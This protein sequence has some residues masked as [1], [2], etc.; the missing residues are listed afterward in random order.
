LVF[1][2]WDSRDTQVKLPRLVASTIRAYDV[3]KL[4]RSAQFNPPLDYAKEA[5]FDEEFLDTG[6]KGTTV[7]SFFGLKAAPAVNQH[8]GIIARGDI[9][10]EAILSLVALRAIGPRGSAGDSVRRYILGISLV[11]LTHDR[12]HDL[13]QGCLLVADPE[14]QSQWEVVSNNG[15]RALVTPDAGAVLT[16]AQ[17]A[18]KSFGVGE[19]R[20]VDFIDKEAAR[21]KIENAMESKGGAKKPKVRRGKGEGSS[22]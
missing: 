22:Q 17:D 11:A 15:S 19:S 20:T 6:Y 10:R 18:A 7:G 13:R 9:R 12:P 16:F 8:G 14:K 4:T 5:L 21:S 1:G 2:A 3:V